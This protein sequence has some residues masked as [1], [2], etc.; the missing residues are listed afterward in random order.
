MT[1]YA[2]YLDDGGHPDDQP[3]LVVAGYVAS[4]EQW[5]EFESKWRNA[6]KRFGLSEPFHMTDFMSGT[7]LSPLRRD[8]ILSALAN[9]VKSSTA[10]PFAAGM[11]MKAYKKV[12]E[13]FALEE[14]HGAPYALTARNVAR[15]FQK[16]RVENLSSGD[17]L[18]VFVEQGTKH[19][20]DLIQVFKRDGLPIPVAVSKSVSRVQAADILA[21]EQF[22][23]LK[24]QGLGARPGK[25]LRRLVDP[26][27]KREQF[28]GIFLETDLRKLCDATSVYPRQSLNPGDTIAYHSE[29]KRKRKR[30][31]Y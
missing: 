26:M 12:N 11:D 28:G 15:S 31:V 6:L 25:N 4:E 7:R 8:Q 27:R 14:C 9:I 24:E 5:R 17:H 16:W 2:L 10:R 22:K 13:E 18:S 30:T 23:Y 21:W 3:A 1:E 19:F 29:K 20:G